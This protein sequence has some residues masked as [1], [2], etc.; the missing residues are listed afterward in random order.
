MK[1][2]SPRPV[3]RP[4]DS[5]LRA[6]HPSHTPEAEGVLVETVEGDVRLTLDDGELLILD[7]G[8]LLSALGVSPAV[9]GLRRAA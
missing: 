1:P 9:V 6:G 2:V 4:S 5:G 8:E 7:R 3:R